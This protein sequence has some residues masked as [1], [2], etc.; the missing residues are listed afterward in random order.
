MLDHFQ[1]WIGGGLVLIALPFVWKWASTKGVDWAVT[2]L[3]NFAV[4]RMKAKGAKKE[5]VVKYLREFDAIIER[6][7]KNIDAE[8]AE[9]EAEPETPAKPEEKKEQPNG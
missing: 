5:D 9:Q 1:A 8:I 6:I 7:D 4:D 3:L 2:K